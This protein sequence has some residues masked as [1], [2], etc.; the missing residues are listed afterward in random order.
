M[1]L[2][3]RFSDEA[4]WQGFVTEKDRS[5]LA[6]LFNR[7]MPLVYGVCLKYLGDREEAKDAAMDVFEKLF[8]TKSSQKVEKFKSW[9]F[10][11]TKNHCLMKLRSKKNS[12]EKNLELVMETGNYVHPLDEEVT[13][14]TSDLQKCL[15]ELKAEQKTCVEMFYLNKKTY[16]EISLKKS[17]DIKQVKSHIQNGKR[18]LKICI[19]GKHE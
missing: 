5:V 15:D 17:I 18:N 7:Y 11:V 2:L 1:E 10:V 16:E 12:T 14:Q 6:L 4:L 9:L 3:D 19:E 8:E 13:D